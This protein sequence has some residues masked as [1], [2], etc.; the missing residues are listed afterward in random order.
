MNSI[1]DFDV[2]DARVL[3]RCDFNVPL[4]ESGNILDDFR[5]VKS[6]PTIEYLIQHKARI[7]LIS[8]LGEPNGQVV[9]NL[10]LDNI[11]SRLQDLLGLPVLKADDCIGIKVEKQAF[12]L[13]PGQILLLENVRFYKE[14]TDNDLIFARK[15]AKLG[16]LYINEAF[17]DC[18]RAHA[19]IV[20]LPAL[21]PSG[22]GFLLEQEIENLN[23]I[24]EN[25]KKPMVAIVGGIKVQ[26]KSQ[27]IEKISELADVVLVSGL[28]QK[29]IMDKNVTFTYPTKIIA[30]ASD[31]EAPD[32]NDQTITLFRQYILEAKTV[33]WNG[34]FGR[35]EDPKY[36][37]GTLEIAKA[38][39]KSKAFCVVGGGETIEF[40]RKEGM[41]DKFSHVSTGGGAMLEYLSGQVLPGLKALE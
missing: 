3:V 40:L 41:I 38:V 6:L 25:P 13:E 33:V 22:I 2:K 26:T 34:P 16:Q 14:E 32:I 9:D 35:F 20:S 4:D 36:K 19:S 15:L 37:K 7:V 12:N 23:K 29:E 18:H 27:F 31:L 8:H 1:K 5:I 21:L 24:L 10:R 39:I 30:P 28:I 17:S 11:K